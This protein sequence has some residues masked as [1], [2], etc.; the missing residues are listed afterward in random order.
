MKTY[1]NLYNSIYAFDNLLLAA[2]NAQKGKRFQDNV[3][4]FNFNLEKEILQLQ[5]ELQTQTY[6]PGNYTTFWITDPKKRMI[7]AAPYRD[8]VVH[9]ALC[10]ITAP[11]FEKTFIFDSYANRKGKGT[12]AAI[13]RYQHFAKQY[14]YVL[15]SDIQKFFPSID[16]DILKAAFRWKI[17]CPQT[18]WL[19]NTILDNSNSQE[20]HIAYFKGDDL[21]TPSQRRRGLPIG[22][23]TS[24][25]WGNIYLNQ[26]DHFMTETLKVS[27]YIRYVDDFVIF[28]ND[29]ACL[30]D[31]NRQMTGFLSQIR[32]VPHPNK[33]HIH[34]VEDG[35]PFLGFQVTPQY[36]VIKKE[37]TKRYFRFI[38][39]K[40][41]MRRLNQISPQDLEN[42]L[43]AWLG[44]VRFGQNKRVENRVFR[45]LRAQ[46]V[47]IF[48]S[49]IDS[50]RVLERV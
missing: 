16:H 37:N 6:Q 4:T 38:S 30:H 2:K 50:W 21:F 48:K 12:H 42:G 22:N 1:K 26:F 8:R 36:R 25:W 33:T 27:G 41:E 7:S 13:E 17:K 44:H 29:K 31:I 10:H 39:K 34:R 49:P 46:G 40:L 11:L 47:N 3:A 20:E 35:V 5:T 9:H 28:D 19:M 43:N 14:K 32:L 45:H 15:K 23:L 24:Q 18:L